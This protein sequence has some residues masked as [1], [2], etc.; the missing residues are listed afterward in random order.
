MV[1]R[2]ADEEFDDSDIEEGEILSDSDSYSNNSDSEVDS[3]H[4]SDEEFI[5]SEYESE[6]EE[7]EEEES[8]VVKQSREQTE[9]LKRLREEVVDMKQELKSLKKQKSEVFSPTTP[10]VP[11]PAKVEEVKVKEEA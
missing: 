2:F 1:K 10:P 8:Q 7:S 3:V 9:E 5:V 11:P 4:T 6:E